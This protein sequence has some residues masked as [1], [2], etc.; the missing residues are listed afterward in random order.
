MTKAKAGSV[1]ASGKLVPS[2]S[3][4]EQAR[5]NA[6][7][8]RATDF[9]VAPAQTIERAA[10]VMRSLS[11]PL[12]DEATHYFFHNFVSDDY[13]SVYSMNAY[14]S[15]LPILHRQDSSFGVLPKIVN[16]I[17]LASISNMKHSPEVMVAASQQYAGALRAINSSIQNSS[18]ATTD[19]TL[20][21][22]MLLGVFEVYFTSKLICISSSDPCADC[23][24]FHSRIYEILGQ[25]RQWSKYN[26]T[27][28]WNGSI[29]YKDW[30][31]HLCDFTSS[32]CKPLTL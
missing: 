6:V 3:L 30:S 20:M 13:S 22:I 19:Q 17:G 12:E 11:A 24:V 31:H 1:C 32:D 4:I 7:P 14:S 9:S 16:A 21:A 5:D 25:S 28:A 8:G 29:A 2:T 15:V 10:T 18:S 27:P 26:S 23:H